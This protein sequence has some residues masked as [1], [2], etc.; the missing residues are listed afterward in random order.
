MN[1]SKYCMNML[2]GFP[3]KHTVLQLMNQKGKL[4]FRQNSLLLHAQGQCNGKAH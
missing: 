2:E 3:H 4:A 1:I